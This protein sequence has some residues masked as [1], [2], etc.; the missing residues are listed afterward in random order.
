MNKNSKI[1]IVTPTEEIRDNAWEEEF[2]KWD[3]DLV[4]NQCVQVL[5]IQSACKLIGHHWDLLIVDEYHHTIKDNNTTEESIYMKLYTMNKY[6]KLLALTAYLPPNKRDWGKLIAPTV[7]TLNTQQAVELGLVSPFTIYNVP[8]PL[9]ENESKV[10]AYI[11]TKIEYLNQKGY[12]GWMWISKRR[13]FFSKIQKRFEIA[14]Q[15]SDYFNDTRGI[16]FS[17]Y[18]EDV[19]KLQEFF[20]NSAS[21]IHSKMKKKERKTSL[22]RYNNKET[23]RIIAAKALNEGVNLVDTYFAVAVTANSSIKDLTQ[24]LGRVIR[25][26]DLGLKKAIYIRLYVPNSRDEYWLRQSQSLH[27]SINCESVEDLFN[28]LNNGV[29]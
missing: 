6:S 28:K 20:G 10:L 15:I 5:C 16:L 29:K 19:K 17:E 2:H 3:A 24:E 18:I 1:L 21:I 7:F 23:N 22:I 8:V 9:N 25:I 11:E 4:Y 12:K 27:S 13:M 14:K 26:D